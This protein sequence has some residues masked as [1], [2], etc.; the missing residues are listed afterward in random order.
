MNWNNPDAYPGKSEEEYTDRTNEEVQSST[1]LLFMLVG[2]FVFI[3]KMAVAFGMFIYAGYSLTQNILGEDINKFKIWSFTVLFTYLI[4]CIIYFLK[5]FIIGLHSKNRKLW[6]LP[7]VICIVLCCV[8][9]AFVV[10]AMVASMF[11][12]TEQKDILCLG[13]S[14]GAFVISFFYIYN[15]YQFKTPTAPGILYWSY[16]LGFR[17]S[18]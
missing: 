12:S 2:L 16:A 5:G 15:I 9:P 4:F 6:I 14:W 17:I 8:F 1:G 18:L 3:L 7:W 13:L 11:K 10:K